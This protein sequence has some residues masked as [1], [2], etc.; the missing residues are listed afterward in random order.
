[1]LLPHRDAV[2]GTIASATTSLYFQYTNTQ[3]F[4]LAASIQL[5]LDPAG[6]LSALLL[7]RMGGVGWRLRWMSGEGLDSC[8]CSSNR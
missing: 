2:Q 4:T 3:T 1:M 5:T 6:F 7:A 8:L